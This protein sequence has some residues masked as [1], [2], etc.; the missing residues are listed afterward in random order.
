MYSSTEQVH[1]VAYSA[2]MAVE[3]CSLILGPTCWRRT[4]IYRANKQ[5]HGSRSF[6]STHHRCFRT[7]ENDR[8]RAMSRTA[9]T[10]GTNNFRTFHRYRLFTD[11]RV[12]HDAA[13]PC[14]TEQCRGA[15][16]HRQLLASSLIAFASGRV[17]EIQC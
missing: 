17:N 14:S 11:D 7:S 10:A 2:L 3:T 15:M 12:D 13:M 5:D 6:T 9:V 4:Y 1:L 8:D 16:N